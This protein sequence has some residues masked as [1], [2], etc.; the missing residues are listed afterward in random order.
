LLAILLGVAFGVWVASVGPLVPSVFVLLTV[1]ALITLAR[2]EAG[3]IG[4]VAV[5]TL[6]PFSVVP[7]RFGFSPTFLDVSLTVLLVAW[8]YRAAQEGRPLVGGIVN[9]LVLVYLGLALASFLL[10]LTYS[11]SPERLRLFLKGI[12]STLF[13]FSVINLTQSAAALRT[14]IAA[15]LVGGAVA[16]CIA[17]AILVLPPETAMVALSALAPLGYP[18]GPGV[19]R[20]IADTDTLRAVGTSIDPNVLGGLLMSVSALLAAQIFSA[21]P[22]LDRRLLWL[23]AVPVLAA[24]LFTYSRTAW[25]GLMVAVAVIATVR[26]R[27]LWL[28]ALGAG[29]LMMLMP[30]GQL[31]VERFLSGMAF[32][33]RAAVM[34]LGEYRDALNLIS[35]YPWFG[36][37]FGET[38]AIGL[39]LGVSSMYLLIGQEMG[40]IGLSSF[41]LILGVV[42]W[43]A[44]AAYRSAA[45]EEARGLLLSAGSVMAAVAAA[46]LFDHYFTNIQFPHMM[47]LFWLCM[48][49]LVSA[50]RLAVHRADGSASRPYR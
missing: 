27:K 46:G 13:F 23:I 50:T 3:I 4:V 28:F 43:Q 37:G 19:L 17:L 12:N 32:Q 2:P 33:D 24:L 49:L 15:L 18:S 39:Y 22:V 26:H 48:G 5:I 30:Q 7:V 41:L 21:R 9:V 14:T 20:P 47:A 35:M 25:G 8:I 1:F 6:L 44:V 42:A 16:A 34:R 29:V 45:N 31:F 36:I 40:L 10:G 38:P 11:V